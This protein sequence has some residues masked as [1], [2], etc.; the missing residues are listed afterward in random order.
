MHLVGER[1]GM[2]VAEAAAAPSAWP[3]PPP[4]GT[5]AACS[6]PGD[7]IVVEVAGRSAW[8]WHRQ[9]R[10][11]AGGAGAVAGRGVSAG[12][13]VQVGDSVRAMSK[14]AWEGCSGLL[15]A[16]PT[17]SL[18]SSRWPTRAGPGRQAPPV[19]STQV[20]TR[21]IGDALEPEARTDWACSGELFGDRVEVTIEAHALGSASWS[22]PAGSGRRP[23]WR[24]RTPTWSGATATPGRSPSTSSCCS[25]RDWTGGV[26]ASRSRGCSWPG[27]RA[28]GVHGGCG[29]LA[30]R[31]VLADQHRTAPL[32]T[33]AALG[34]ATLQAARRSR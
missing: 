7:R 26:G 12:W 13:V 32:A 10:L 6:P 17:L 31:Q 1:V 4:Y 2:P 9:G 25:A 21:P 8:A 3:W 28:A 27:E 30:A 23:A 24:R 5:P 34:G 19:G 22:W 29:A 15:A 14:A 20:P 18:A 16:Q 11:G 33:A